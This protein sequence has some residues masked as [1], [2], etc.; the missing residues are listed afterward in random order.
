M[1][2]LLAEG[3]MPYRAENS[4]KTPISMWS[5]R[6]GS[7]QARLLTKHTITP[8]LR[9]S[10]EDKNVLLSCIL[11]FLFPGSKRTMR[12]T[13]IIADPNTHAELNI[14]A[15]ASNTSANVPTPLTHVIIHPRVSLSSTIISPPVPTNQR[16]RDKTSKRYL[17]PGWS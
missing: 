1:R 9:L 3:S 2:D 11:K 4:Y 12:S 7:S 8:K 5:K 17:L 15:R 6:S 14:S 13:H 10:E 16:F